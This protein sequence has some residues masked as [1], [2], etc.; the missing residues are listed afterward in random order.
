MVRLEFG[1]TW[2]I[3]G[4]VVV[5]VLAIY[6]VRFLWR[7]PPNTRQAFVVA[8][9]LFVGGAIGVEILGGWYGGLHGMAN[10][11]YSLFATVEE[12]MEIVGVIVFIHALLEYLAGH[13]QEVRLRLGDAEVESSQPEI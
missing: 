9:T 6:F 2:V 3:P 13:F 7:L 5:A 4:M 11:T 8:G 12:S 1:F 10:L